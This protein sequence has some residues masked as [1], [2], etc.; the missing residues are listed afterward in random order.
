MSY[1]PCLAVQVVDELLKNEGGANEVR[2]EVFE[3]SRCRRASD[4]DGGQDEVDDEGWQRQD[5]RS[6]GC[7]VDTFDLKRL[8]KQR[9][10]F[11]TVHI[12]KAL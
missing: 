2:L 3:E 10:K 5:M 1:L 8:R 7:L 12:I 4:E 11:Q 6:Q 9:R